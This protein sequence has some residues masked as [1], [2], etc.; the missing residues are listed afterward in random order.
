[1]SKATVFL[2]KLLGLYCLII[3]GAMLAR[4]SF[5][6]DAVSA[7]L[8]D[9]AMLYTLGVLLLFAGLAMVLVHN[10]WRGRPVTVIV[11]VMGWL[12]LLKGVAFV[13]LLPVAAND[14]YLVELRFEQLYYLYAVVTLALGA[15]LT[16]RGFRPVAL[17]AR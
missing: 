7:L 13:G 9:P 17:A 11:T 8:H 14:L 6:L 16:Y 1:M 15:Y 2:S 4:R 3:A 5:T 12:T 10:F